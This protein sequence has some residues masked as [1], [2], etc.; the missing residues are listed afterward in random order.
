MKRE[1]QVKVGDYEHHSA[2]NNDYTNLATG[3]KNHRH[4]GT[5]YQ[6]GSSVEKNEKSSFSAIH[7]LL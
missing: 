6:S 3:P 4:S 5:N 7:T 2:V 1:Y